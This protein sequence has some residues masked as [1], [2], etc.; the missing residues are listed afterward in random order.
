MHFG[1]FD[2]PLIIRML[3]VTMRAP[4]SV[5]RMSSFVP[6]MLMMI[7]RNF[8]FFKSK[9]RL[10]LE[11]PL[12]LAESQQRLITLH[13]WQLGRER[14]ISAMAGFSEQSG[15]LCWFLSKALLKH[16]NNI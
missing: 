6:P 13:N 4:S 1:D 10:K 11:L 9:Q 2:Y 16:I 5:I 14:V 8:I 3:L 15:K 7:G 12:K